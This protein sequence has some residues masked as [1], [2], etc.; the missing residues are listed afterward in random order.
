VKGRSPFTLLFYCCRVVPV[1]VIVMRP[2]AFC[3]RTGF[4]TLTFVVGLT[5]TFDVVA[6][7]VVVFVREE[8]VVAIAGDPEMLAGGLTTDAA[9][10]DSVRTLANDVGVET[11]LL[12][13]VTAVP[14]GAM[15]GAAAFVT[16]V[17]ALGAT[18]EPAIVDAAVADVDPPL[19]TTT[20][21]ESRKPAAASLLATASPAP[22]VIASVG[23]ELMEELMVYRVSRCCRGSIKSETYGR[24]LLPG[25]TGPRTRTRGCCCAMIAAASSADMRVIDD[26]MGGGT[27]SDSEPA[28]VP[29]VGTERV[30]GVTTGSPLPR[31]RSVVQ[32]NAAMDAQRETASSD[33]NTG[34]SDKLLAFS[35]LLM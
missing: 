29:P 13:G 9:V 20:P 14:E 18:D 6:V 23:C 2:F 7:R 21:L 19:P 32:P 24:P 3:T 4:A 35:D 31:L 17:P 12:V 34:R 10:G 16:L 26:V 27:G 28:D 30:P 11:A 8:L 5:V 22:L 25:D 15:T 33:R 1:F